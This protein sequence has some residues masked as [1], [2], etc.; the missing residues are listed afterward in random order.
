MVRSAARPEPRGRGDCEACRG[1][2]T[3]EDVSSESSA[4][5]WIS[6]FLA[7]RAP[8]TPGSPATPDPG[9]MRASDADRERVVTVL[10]DAV[11][12]GRLTPLEHEERV[13]RV[14]AARTLGELAELT[15]DLLPPESQPFRM[16]NRPVTAF[17]RTET[18]GGRWVVPSQIPVTSLG[19][20]VSMDLCEALL[21]SRH[22]VVQLAVMAGTVTLLVPEGVRIV[23]APTARVRSFRNEVRLPAGATDH[24]PDAPVIE[25][26]GFVFGGKVVARSPKRPRRRLFGR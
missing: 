13:E 5:K 25:L 3:L 17:F 19:G 20:T 6:T 2:H 14:W 23:T 10:T 4:A 11:I 24:A 9:L 1:P 15:V 22:V 7:S 8:G 21:Q 16:D 18:R 26:A 12:D